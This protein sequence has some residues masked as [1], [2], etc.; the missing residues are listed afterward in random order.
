MMELN[1]E[2]ARDNMIKRQLRTWD[3]LDEAVL[4]VFATV[5]RERFVPERYIN[6]AFADL[7]IPLGHHQVMMSPKIEGRML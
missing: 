5:P 4:E 1:I 3:V 6:L 7:E 2:K